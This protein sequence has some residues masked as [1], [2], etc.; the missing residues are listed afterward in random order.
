LTAKNVDGPTYVVDRIVGH[1]VATDG[2]LEFDVK[3]YGYRKH[4]RE[5]RTNVPEE[6]ISRH[7][8]HRRRKAAVSR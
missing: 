2:T 1:R 3:W 8:A 4:T 7:F 6:L 5:P